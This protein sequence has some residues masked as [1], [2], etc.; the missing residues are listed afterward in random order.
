MVRFA[1]RAD[2]GPN[3]DATSP[4]AE[5]VER[6]ERI[7]KSAY[8]AK[9]VL[10]Q[11]QQ[12]LETA[13]AA[14]Q[15]LDRQH[16]VAAANLLKRFTD[17]VAREYREKVD[18]VFRLHDVLCGISAAVPPDSPQK[19]EIRMLYDVVR[20]PRF[21]LPSTADENE[22]LAQIEHLPNQDKIAEITKLWGRHVESL[23]TDADADISDLEAA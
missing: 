5:L 17:D 23:L 7:R 8:A 10:P 16:Y 6:E 2:I 3:G 19:G 9:L 1:G 15:H 13:R 4:F 20:V 21:D 11:K 14:V 22:Y 12:E 18:D